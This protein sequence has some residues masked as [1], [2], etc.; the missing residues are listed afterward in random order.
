MIREEFNY[1]SM[2]TY[3]H[4]HIDILILGK[5]NSEERNKFFFQ[6]WE[7]TGKDI[8]IIDLVNDD[9][10]IRCDI[11]HKR[12]WENYCGEISQILPRILSKMNTVQSNVLI[13][14][15]SLHQV[16]LMVLIKVLIKTIK[17]KTLFASYIRPQKYNISDDETT[18]VL[19]TKI[20]EVKS[21]PKF[22]RRRRP[23][24]V[25][26]SF[27][28]FEGFRYKNILES[29][30]DIK[31]TRVV[32]AFPS[33]FPH[34]FNTTMWN[35]MDELLDDNIDS[36][37]YKCFS[38]SVFEA[39]SLLN[40]YLSKEPNIILAPIGT[41]VHAAACAIFGSMY[42][43]VNIIYDYA[44]ESDNRTVGIDEIII[45]HLSSFIEET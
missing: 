21:I 11:M 23:D 13:D 16:A 44:V 38:E 15:T 25:L 6:S 35:A 26:C 18:E 39:V 7:N 43:N 22:T 40:K 33:G 3:L 37:V 20:S 29:L 12:N 31:R 30:D 41:R 8:I 36:I 45:Y 14:L 24:S 19:T 42:N 28:G 5:P 27:I 17:P 2:K 10:I 34:W 4:Q 9:N 1:N 32:A